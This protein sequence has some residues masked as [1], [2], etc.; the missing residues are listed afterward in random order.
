VHFKF[1]IWLLSGTNN[2]VISIFSR[3]GIF[4]QIFSSP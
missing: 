2:Q 1:L 3:W 4:P